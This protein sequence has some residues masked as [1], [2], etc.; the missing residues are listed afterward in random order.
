MPISAELVHQMQNTTAKVLLCHPSHLGAALEAASQAGIPRSRIFQ[1]SDV[2]N[3]TAQGIQD[4]RTGLAGTAAEG[5]AYA[6]PEFSGAEARRTV[7]TINYSSGTTG[8]PKGVC[9]SH[10][11][12]VA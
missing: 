3:P 8:L 11:N 10:V 7:A 9:V 4:W 2:E 1:F 5:S 6:W 12:L